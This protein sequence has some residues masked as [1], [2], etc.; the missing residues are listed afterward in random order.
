MRFAEPVISM[1]V[2]PHSPAESEK[3]EDVLNK[4]AEE[5]PT[6]KVRR[7]EET[8]QTIISGMGELHLQVL[9]E[10]AFREFSIRI[11]MGIPSVA[12]RETIEERKRERASLSARPAARR[13]T[14]T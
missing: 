11:R 14:D 5:D 3:M 6:F 1:A 8:G 12:Y 13:S 10:R 9:G 4:L 2:E 7:D